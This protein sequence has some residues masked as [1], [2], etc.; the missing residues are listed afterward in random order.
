MGRPACGYK[1]REIFTD[2]TGPDTPSTLRAIELCESCPIRVECAE[3]AL[4]A[5]SSLDGGFVS[6]A[7]GVIQAGV[8]CDGSMESVWKLATIAGVPPPIMRESTPRARVGDRC[9]SCHRPMVRWHRGVTPEGYVMHRGRGFCTGCR[10]AYNAELRAERERS[11][12]KPRLRKIIDR[13]NHSAPKRTER[14]VVIQYALFDR[15]TLGA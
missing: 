8:Y 15:E 12:D 7:V 14:E 6:A 9:R 13:K 10:T 4:S 1:H 2:P 11:G 5:G 3:K